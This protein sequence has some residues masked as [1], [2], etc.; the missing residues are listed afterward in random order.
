[1]DSLIGQ[2]RKI[3]GVFYFFCRPGLV[4]KKV[5]AWINSGEIKSNVKNDSHLISLGDSYPNVSVGGNQ[6]A[7]YGFGS[8]KYVFFNT[9]SGFLDSNASGFIYVPQG[10]DPQNCSED[11]DKEPR[12]RIVSLDNNWF[13]VSHY[14][15]KPFLR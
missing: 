6:V 14:E 8:N 15:C 10:G 2:Y 5:S 1:M 11:V 7:V 4:V 9:F 13:C 12:A 3:S